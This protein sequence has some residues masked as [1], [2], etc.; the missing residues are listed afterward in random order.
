M[1]T[2]QN[3]HQSQVVYD[4]I[5]E[6]LEANKQ[7]NI[8]HH[9]ATVNKFLLQRMVNYKKMIRQQTINQINVKDEKIL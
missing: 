4:V 2:A 9:F 8:K 6:F 7:D 1:I 3:R 5:Q